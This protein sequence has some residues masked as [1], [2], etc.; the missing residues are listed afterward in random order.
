MLSVMK[1]HISRL[2][3]LLVGHL[4]FGIGFVGIFI[5]GL[6]TVP[7]WIIATW[8]YSKSCPVLEERLLTHPKYGPYLRDWKKDRIIPQ[9]AKILATTM[10]AIS[11]V[12]MILMGVSTLILAVAGACM[13]AG[14]VYIFMRPSV[15][16][17][18]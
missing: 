1:R 10:M 18:P 4:F 6:P 5:P 14:L 12:V 11:F 3:Y 8:A 2:T 7:L 17:N 9:R 15:R 13:L 16:Q